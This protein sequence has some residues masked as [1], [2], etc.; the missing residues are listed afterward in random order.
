M[1]EQFKKNSKKIDNHNNGI[2]ECKNDDN[3]VGTVTKIKNNQYNFLNNKVL[4]SLEEAIV[5]SG[6]KDGMTIS[7][8]HAFRHGDKT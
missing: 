7:F 2:Y 6:L 3:S 4:N 1:I 8:H 5:K